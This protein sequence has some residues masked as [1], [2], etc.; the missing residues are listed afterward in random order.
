MSGTVA[1]VLRECSS[2]FNRA[3]VASSGTSEDCVP[4]DWGFGEWVRSR[5]IASFAKL[6]GS[7]QLWRVGPNGRF[8]TWRSFPSTY[9]F[10]LRYVSYLRLMLVRDKASK[11]LPA[12]KNVKD[13]ALEVL[14]TLQGN[15]GRPD[16]GREYIGL[17]E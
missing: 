5:M 4:E 13:R 8:R 1:H 7:R 3:G 14:G 2:R 15:K 9:S 6:F 17:S 10:A 12:M 16:D 11:V